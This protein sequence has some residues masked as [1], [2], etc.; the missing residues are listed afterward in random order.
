MIYFKQEISKKT[1]R[2]FVVSLSIME[3]TE[4]APQSTGPK[5]G[6]GDRMKKYEAKFMQKIDPKLPFIIRLDGHKFS[7]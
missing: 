2:L 4:Q 3:A 7:G 1:W 6:L 5:E